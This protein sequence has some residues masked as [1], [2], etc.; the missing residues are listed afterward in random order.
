MINYAMGETAFRDGMRVSIINNHCQGKLY[1][2]VII[3]IIL[4]Y[5]TFVKR[6]IHKLME[7]IINIY[8]VIK[9]LFFYLLPLYR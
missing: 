8:H 6:I 4:L 3:I 9:D 5:T 7:A 1:Y 2:N